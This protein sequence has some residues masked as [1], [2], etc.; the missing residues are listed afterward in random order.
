MKLDTLNVDQLKIGLEIHCQLT[1]LKTK[2]FCGCLCNY[3]NSQPNKNTCPICLGLP[4]SLPLLNKRA[5][6][7]ASMICLAF[8]CSI[9]D[10]ISFYRKNYFY[11]DLPK[12]FQITQYNSYEL[13]SIGYDGL[14][15]FENDLH[16]EINKSSVETN[17]PSIRIARIQLE[18]DPG[19]IVYEDDNSSM[20]TYSLIDY[21]RA[22][23]ALVEIVTEPDF[24]NP[25]DVRI[26]LN[27]IINI[28]EY[29]NVCDPALEGSI[30]CDVNVSIKGGKKVEIKNISSFKDV[31]KS[32]YYE[33]TRQKTLLMHDIKVQAETRHWDEKRKITISARSKEEEEDY[34][35]FPEPDIP[36]IGLGGQMFVSKMKSQ[37]NELPA[38]RLERYKNNFKIT[39]H[40]A[41]I[42]VN[43]KKIS[44][45]FEE[46]LEFY[47]SPVEVSN[48]IVNELLTKI[49][50]IEKSDTSKT[51]TDRLSDSHMTPRLI[52]SMAKLVEEKKVNRN[53]AREI[54]DNCLR[55]GEDPEEM[56]KR[57]NTTKISDADEIANLIRKIVS[58]QPHLVFQSKSNANVNNFILG[59]IMKE[60]KGKADPQVAMNTIREILSKAD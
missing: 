54:F 6:E 46:S 48:W 5:V 25:S 53:I 27:E 19:K 57:L 60:T 12:N 38:E 44:D 39:S 49:N 24:S 32:L 43:S 34:K 36:R 4:G 18:E 56:A 13:S 16:S 28:F 9:P 29:L 20:N 22:G 11:P 1:H 41:R 37:M 45:F 47:H 51:S 7:F 2:L 26:F 14:Y 42:L 50:E 35:Y 21:N 52:A 40:T 17:T 30:R 55:T 8:N 10:K 15:N 3:R 23:V 33:I 59:L 58:D 31:E